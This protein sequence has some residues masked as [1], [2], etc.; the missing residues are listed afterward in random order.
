MPPHRSLMCTQPGE[1][2]AAESYRGLCGPANRHREDGV[3]RAHTQ[4]LGLPTRNA[5]HGTSTSPLQ[6]GK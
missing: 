5:K 4:G 6:P 3:S 2:E 1:K